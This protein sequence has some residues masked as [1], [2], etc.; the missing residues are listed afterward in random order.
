MDLPEAKRIALSLADKALLLSARWFQR[1]VRRVGQ[2]LRSCG[3]W[4]LSYDGSNQQSEKENMMPAGSVTS[5]PDRRS[6][7]VERSANSSASSKEFIVRLARLAV[8]LWRAR[9]R[10]QAEA[11]IHPPIR[12]VLRYLETAFGELED[13]GITLADYTGEAYEPGMSA[14]I[15]TVAWDERS[16]CA[17]PTI[18]E[19][20]APAVF[21]C[22][23]PI[24]RSEA[25]IG[26]P[27]LSPPT[28]ADQNTTGHIGQIA[29]APSVA[30][31]SPLV[32][33]GENSL[34]PVAD[35]ATHAIDEASAIASAINGSA[36][37][38]RASNITEGAAKPE[39][40]AAI[41]SADLEDSELS[42][43]PRRRRRRDG[44]R[45][46]RPQPKPDVKQ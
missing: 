33:Q 27:P 23:R 41:P 46:R 12:M 44:V 21:Y 38:Q 5:E 37:L 34:P 3:D 20:I 28:I 19:T 31:N 25:T 32:E 45:P 9:R 13:A 24:L 6:A 15:R 29:D 7:V 22:G 4:V 30:P 2:I 1:A 17:G 18:V 39:A 26:I 43:T 40:S 35:G 42:R 11:E 10:A 8:P 16:E 36:P 14:F